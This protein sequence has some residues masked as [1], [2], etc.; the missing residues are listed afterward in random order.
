MIEYNLDC[1]SVWTGKNKYRDT[2]NC[3]IGL[4]GAKRKMSEDIKIDI[5]KD[6]KKALV[7]MT[8]PEPSEGTSITNMVEDLANIVKDKE[9]PELEHN[10]IK[11]MECYP[12]GWFEPTSP[13][14]K[15]VMFDLVDKK[16]KNPRWKDLREG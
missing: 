14:C 8:N 7:I 12:K 5:I 3:D 9:L 10:K 2:L 1:K 16:Y 13:K 6:E 15:I 4:V 11:W